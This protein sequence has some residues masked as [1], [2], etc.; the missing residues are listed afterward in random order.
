MKK[1]LPIWQSAVIAS[2][3]LAGAV[4]AA[5]ASVDTPAAAGSVSASDTKAATVLAPLR[6]VSETAGAKVAW[7]NEERTVTLSLGSDTITLAIGK[8]TAR[9]NDKEVELGAAVQIKDEKAFVPLSFLT[10]ALHTAVS[11]DPQTG[12]LII[13]KGDL[14]AAASAFAS[15]WLQ[16]DNESAVSYFNE[17]LKKS[18]NANQLHSISQYY[19]NMYGPITGQLGAGTASNSVHE[20]VYLTYET[21]STVPFQMTV[22]FDK[23]E[24]ID[25]LYIPPYYSPDTYRKPSYDDSSAYVEKE[26]KLGEGKLV[27]PGTLTLPNKPGPHPVV[28]LVHG[29]GANDRDES[30]GGTKLFRD[31]AVG[32]A[33]EG[34]ATLRYEKVTRE[35][36]FKSAT[37]TFTVQ[38]ET[39][40]DAV[41]AVNQLAKTEGIDPQRIFVA[42][43]SQGG[44][45]VPR[46]IDGV[47]D[48]KLAGAVVLAGP[49]NSIEDVVLEQSKYQL[50]VSRERG[51]DTSILEQQ[52]AFW[53][54]QL[55]L[56]KDPQYSVDNL[57]KDLA[58]SNA[59]WW[60]DFRNY[61]ASE[62]AKKQDK[63]MLILQGDNDAQVLA[64]HLDKWKEA[65]KD[66][67]NV[68]YKLYPKLNHVFAEVDEKSTGAEYNEPANTPASVIKDI[69]DWVKKT[70]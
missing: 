45:I 16:G 27:L 55:K 37:P 18:L 30:I 68:E 4:P 17:D 59:Y 61:S 69:A 67:S 40:A 1:H 9:I 63:P 19:T 44:M 70:K 49:T 41:Y 56:I 36:P 39:V 8:S 52:V 43:H 47:K 31:M 58:L 50:E 33:A 62:I 2:M 64:Y 7:N 3:L 13:P 46:I 14:K 26:V 53:E 54:Q 24:R 21:Q 22:R 57:P 6:L 20:N 5:A 29:S 60:M 32:L 11:W 51:L 65:L 38:D 10:E 35:H 25:D 12:K 34:I 28:V 48:V 42:G 66:R 15:H 23:Q